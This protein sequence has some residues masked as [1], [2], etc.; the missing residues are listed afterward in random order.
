MRPRITASKAIITK[1]E[2]KISLAYDRGDL[3]ALR[4]AQGLLGVLR[5]DFYGD[6][7]QLIGVTVETI[8]LWIKS[9]LVDG[10]TSLK[11]KR[12]TG[13]PPKLTKEQKRQ[14]R[15]AIKKD[16][17]PPVIRLAVGIAPLCKTSSKTHFRF[18]TQFPTLLNFSKA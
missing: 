6:V 2:E 3:Q 4:R 8:R 17:R 16:R 18:F 11:F 5:G 12:S 13:R 7:A 9:F 15:Q 14:L 10:L 1:L